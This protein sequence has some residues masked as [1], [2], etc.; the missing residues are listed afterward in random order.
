ME[1][2]FFE[3]NYD[4]IF[5]EYTIPGVMSAILLFILLFYR[6]QSKPLFLRR[7]IL[8]GVPLFVLS[9]FWGVMDEIRIY[10]EIYGIITLLIA[11][12]AGLMTGYR[13]ETRPRQWEF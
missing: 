1:F 10:Y 13:M 5:S 11:H 9:I 8:I 2:N 7:A 3:H 4:I 12:S 6:W